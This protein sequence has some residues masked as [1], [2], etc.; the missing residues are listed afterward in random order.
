MDADLRTRSIDSIKAMRDL[1]KNGQID[2][3][4]F[5]KSMVCLAYEFALGEE[6]TWVTKL[7]LEVPISY[8]KDTQAQQCMDDPDYAELC[9]E[10]S[11]LLI[12]YGM[13]DMGPVI[14]QPP[15]VA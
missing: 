7:L 9:L 15:G 1:H 3:S 14:N 12:L 8:Y 4:T 10:L 2:D 6:K 13:V 5:Y 11:K